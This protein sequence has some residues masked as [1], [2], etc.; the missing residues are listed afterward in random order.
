MFAPSE[1]PHIFEMAAKGSRRGPAHVLAG[2]VLWAA[3]TACGGVTEAEPLGSGGAVVSSTG[4]AADDPSAP[5]SSGGRSSSDP[6]S[7]TTGGVGGEDS[8]SLDDP[9]R[10]LEPL[11]PD[12]V[13]VRGLELAAATTDFAERL[14]LEAGWSFVDLEILARPNLIWALARSTSEA[15]LLVFDTRSC[16]GP[17]GQ[18]SVPKAHVEGRTLALSE[19]ALLSCDAGECVVLRGTKL[20]PLAWTFPP[21]DYTWLRKDGATYCAGSE[22]TLTCIRGDGVVSQ[23]LSWAAEA[24]ARG[25]LRDV[26]NCAVF[27]TSQLC[28]TD[29]GSWQ[30]V[31]LAI[32]SPVV[33]CAAPW[34]PSPA[35]T[36]ALPKA[37]L[38]PRGVTTTVCGGTDNTQLVS[39]RFFGMSCNCSF[40]G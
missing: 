17:I 24:A 1:R 25:A 20:T 36:C 6:E 21:G 30:E 39:E 12:L 2:V 40:V 3:L 8:I 10:D 26:G 16:D 22:A 32:N 31:P 38:T 28:L 18:V 7:S 29:D 4:G 23:P 27:E 33:P 15:V 34:L 19:D 37:D 9:A 35:A 13:T 11:Q 14:R 5:P